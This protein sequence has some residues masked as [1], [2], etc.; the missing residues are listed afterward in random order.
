MCLGRGYTGKA[1]KRV[2][3]LDPRSG[4]ELEL[5]V[6]LTFDE[7]DIKAIYDYERDDAAGRQNA[8]GNVFGPALRAHQENEGV[9]AAR[10]EGRAGGLTPLRSSDAV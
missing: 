1:V 2:Y 5:S 6:R 9:G 3:A 8:F 4:A 7:A 10:R